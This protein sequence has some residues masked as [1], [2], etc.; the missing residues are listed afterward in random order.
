MTEHPRIGICLSGGGFRASFYGLGCLRYLAEAGLLSSVA[1]IS[2]VSGGSITAAALA[3]RADLLAADDFSTESFLTHVDRPFRGIVTTTNLRNRWIA[4]SALAR[5]RG[6]RVGRGRVLGELLGEALY[7]TGELANLPSGPQVILTATDLTTGRAFR[8]SRDFVGSYDFGYVEPA[9]ES[10]ELGFAV[11]ASASVPALFPP[12]SLA[13]KGLGLRDAPDTLSLADGGVYDNLGL[14]WFQGW[15]SGRPPSAVEVSFTIV[16]NAGRPLVRGTHPYGGVRGAFRA[17]DV[18]YVQTTRLRSRWYVGEL[19][20]GRGAGA[21]IATELD[22]R[23]FTTV[24]R[25]PIDTG[26]YEGALPASL[27]KPLAELRTDLDRFHPEEAALLSYHGYWS[28]HARLGSLYPDLAIERPGW[29]EFA[30]L[31]EA[32]TNAY[33]RLLNGGAR[34]LRLPHRA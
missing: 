23:G 19:L 22:P 30:N 6:R 9:P 16:V 14:E 1:A 29:Q 27:V 5:L 12:A 8:M 20:A 25:A 10:I 31:S 11:A 3:D 4:S 7:R 15:A 18:Q 17:K 32:E 24:D 34:R 13:S 2:S 26:L 33:R 28:L 21:Y